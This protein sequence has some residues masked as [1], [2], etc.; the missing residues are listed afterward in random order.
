MSEKIRLD[1]K[2]PAWEMETSSSKVEKPFCAV[3]SETFATK[4]KREKAE[5][6]C[7]GDKKTELP[8]VGEVEKRKKLSKSGHAADCV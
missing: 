8:D 5:E 3:E 2:L 6:N 1:S 4:S 7:D